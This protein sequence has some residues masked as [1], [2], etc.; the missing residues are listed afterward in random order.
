[1][2]NETEFA[3]TAESE[4]TGTADHI[5]R[6]L[7]G[8]WAAIITFEDG[9]TERGLFAF[10]SDRLM[11]QTNTGSR[12]T[13]IGVWEPTRRGFRYAFREQA[14]N[15]E[16]QFEFDVHV[17]HVGELTSSNSFT[18]TGTGTAIDA[19]GNVLQVTNTTVTAERYGLP[20]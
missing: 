8:T 20:R 11:V 3:A 2:S 13:G 19:D 14:F 1:M 16:G 7:V 12:F 6:K 17:D 18:S 10:T 4:N 9:A 5:H 15:D